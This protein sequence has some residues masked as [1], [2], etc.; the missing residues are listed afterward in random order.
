MEAEFRTFNPC[1]SKIR[2]GMSEMSESVFQVQSMAPSLTVWEIGGPVKITAAKQKAFDIRR[3]TVKIGLHKTK[4][5]VRQ[6]DSNSDS[7]ST[8]E[9]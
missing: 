9:N 1:N 4:R 8:T 6:I 2:A 5:F 3:A 7:P